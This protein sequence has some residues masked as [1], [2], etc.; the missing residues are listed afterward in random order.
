MTR[1]TVCF[2]SGVALSLA[3]GWY[4]FPRILYRSA[5]QPIQFSHKVH[6]VTN[7]MKC[8]DCHSFRADGTFA[9]IPAIDKCAGCHAAQIGTTADEK[10]LVTEYVTPNREI[11]W[12]TYARQPDN[13]WFPHA[14]HVNLAKLQCE[15]CHGDQG[16]SD[17]LRPHEQNRISTYSRAVMKMDDCESCHQQKHVEAGCLSCHK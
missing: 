15:R 5:P 8:E 1:G 14:V 7:G 2:L 11:P 4:A 3:F 17:R 13:A 9:G 12:N 6:T 16:K 10:V